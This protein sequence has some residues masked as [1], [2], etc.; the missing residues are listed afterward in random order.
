MIGPGHIQAAACRKTFRMAGP[1][2]RAGCTQSHN[3]DLHVAAEVSATSSFVAY[4]RSVYL[5]VY[6]FMA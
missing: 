1:A 6:L 5:Y 3:I 4:S 2:V